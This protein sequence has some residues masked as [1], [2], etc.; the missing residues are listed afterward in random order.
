[1][2]GQES[3]EMNAHKTRL[4]LLALGAV[5]IGAFGAG[6]GWA[7]L[8]GGAESKC[9]LLGAPRVSTAESVLVTAQ[10]MTRNLSRRP[11]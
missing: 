6:I 8:G 9:E 10:T 1:M 7:V 3:N 11:R 2:N 5:L 4:G